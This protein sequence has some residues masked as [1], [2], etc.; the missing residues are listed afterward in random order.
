D[1]QAFNTT[2]QKL[3]IDTSIRPENIR[4][5][6][7]EYGVNI[8]PP[9]ATT[10]IINR[11]YQHRGIDIEEVIS[12]HDGKYHRAKHDAYELKLYNKGIQH[13][14]LTEVFRIE[15]KTTN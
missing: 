5:T 15:I 4:I 11:C 12:R 13:H 2:I 3:F 9:I 6:G 1:E 10:E 14:Q 7:L 8:T